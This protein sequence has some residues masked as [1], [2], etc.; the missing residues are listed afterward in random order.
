MG[1][2]MDLF[3]PLDPEEYH[4]PFKLLLFW[5]YV[6]IRFTSELFPLIN[7]SHSPLH[8][9]GSSSVVQQAICQHSAAP[10]GPMLYV[11]RQVTSLTTCTCVPPKAWALTMS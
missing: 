7:P 9:S 2:Y 11:P 8:L 3:S 5:F 10:T 4:K 1:R 6:T